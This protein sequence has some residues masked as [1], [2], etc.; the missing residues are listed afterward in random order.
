MESNYLG[1]IES[2]ERRHQ[3]QAVRPDVELMLEPDDRI[4]VRAAE[5]LESSLD[6][7]DNEILGTGYAVP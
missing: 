7:W 6:N 2:T 4:T 3:R 5:R 1:Q